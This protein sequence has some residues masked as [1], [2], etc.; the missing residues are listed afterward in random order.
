ADRRFA[1]DRARRARRTERS[2]SPLRL[3]AR[4]VRPVDAVHVDRPAD[5]LA[6]HDPVGHLRADRRARRARALARAAAR[7]ADRR[8]DPPAR[9]DPRNAPARADR[10][11]PPRA[12]VPWPPRDSLRR[13]GAPHRLRARARGRPRSLLRRAPRDLSDL[14]FAR[15]RRPAPQRRS[16]PAQTGHVHARALPRLRPRVPESAP[17]AR[18]PR[19]LLPPLLRPTRRSRHGADV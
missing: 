9:S 3:A 15:P 19:L 8:T 14:R 17:D 7:R 5:V 2:V 4:V 11:L 16:P 13:R 18:R 12:H 10:A 1:R 6:A